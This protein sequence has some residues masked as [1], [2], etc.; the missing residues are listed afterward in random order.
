MRGRRFM[1][2]DVHEEKERLRR[3]ILLQRSKLR[4]A[5]LQAAAVEL[6]DVLLGVPEV[7]R[8]AVV[9]AYVGVGTEPGTGPLLDALDRRGIR[10]LL[11][12]LGRELDLDWAAYTGPGT[13]TRARFGLLEPSG[14]RLGR[15]AVAT[16][17]AV[18]VPGLAVDRTGMRLGRGGGSYDRALPRIAREAFSCV[19]LHDGEV[20]EGSVPSDRDDWRVRAAATPSGLIRF[21]PP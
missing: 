14:H 6:C 17:D 3:R 11:P 9:P 4:P 12:V 15:D 21:P 2:Y 16:A 10:V 19:L 1:P 18:L 13:L 20:L 7:S 5:D 8:A